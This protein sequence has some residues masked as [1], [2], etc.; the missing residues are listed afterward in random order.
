MSN[1]A[2]PNV[3]KYYKNIVMPVQ[4]DLSFVVAAADSAGYGVTNLKSNGYVQNVF[5]NTSA[6]PAAGNPNPAAGYAVVQL[7]DNYNVFLGMGMRAIAPVTGSDLTAV[8]AGTPYVITALG[9]ATA[10]QWLA[11]GL[12]AGFTAAV[13]QSFVAI[14]S[15]TIGGSAT[16]KAVGTSGIDHIEIV[17]DPSLTLANSQVAA[18]G[19]GYAIVKF[20]LNSTATAPNA[21]SVIKLSFLL[22]N[23]SVTVDG[24]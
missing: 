11:A 7:K 1:R 16:V 23:S 4:I 2:F 19:G 18:Y 17:G 10:A 6:T 15:A 24:I 22:D 14:A 12:P 3:G 8:V 5:M 9:T 13:G 20:L 21:G